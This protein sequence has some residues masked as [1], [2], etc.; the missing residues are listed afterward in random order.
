M[1]VWLIF[2]LQVVIDSLSDLSCVCSS[3]TDT[4]TDTDTDSRGG[5]NLQ[6]REA[7]H[8]T[9]VYSTLYMNSFFLDRLGV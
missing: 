6:Y 4:Y 1:D 3:S 7:F 8:Y 9:T 2:I 5:R